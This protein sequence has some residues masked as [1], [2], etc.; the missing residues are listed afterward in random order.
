MADFARQALAQDVNIV[1]K[2]EG[3]L[4]ALLAV[5]G[6]SDVQVMAPGTAVKVY[7]AK[8][9]LSDAAV[10]E[11][12]EIPVSGYEMELAEVGE[13][14]YSKYR[15]VT[16]I[17]AIGKQGYNV[18]VGGTNAA[19]LKDLQKRVRKSI[20]DGIAKSTGTATPVFFANPELVSR[21]SGSNDMQVF[22]RRLGG[23]ANRY[24][25]QGISS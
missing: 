18:A 14:A 23:R 5:L 1:N 19:M 12:A 17:E 21:D 9:S 2:F 22:V 10:A 3:D 11:G 16:P 15:N 24:S 8:G 7:K 25:E 6:K 20:Y 13:L 4:A